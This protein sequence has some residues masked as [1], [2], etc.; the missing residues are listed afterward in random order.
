[1]N[2]FFKKG[3]Q[4]KGHN[5]NNGR[6]RKEYSNN[7]HPKRHQGHQSQFQKIY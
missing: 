7:F 1:M 2:Q 4:N 6:Q 3:N 5:A